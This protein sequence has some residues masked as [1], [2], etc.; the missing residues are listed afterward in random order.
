MRGAE[1]L[2]CSMGAD[3]LENQGRDPVFQCVWFE[4]E[5]YGN[6]NPKSRI[7]KVQGPLEGPRAPTPSTLRTLHP[8]SEKLHLDANIRTI[9]LKPMAW[10]TVKRSCSRVRYVHRVTS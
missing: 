6:P 5:G 10:R 7:L 3:P 1:A 8:S 4:E 2:S 9:T